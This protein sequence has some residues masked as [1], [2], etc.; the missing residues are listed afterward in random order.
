MPAVAIE[1]GAAEQVLPTDRIATALT[2]LINET[3]SKQTT[4]NIA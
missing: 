4:Q 2:A 1:L 3:H